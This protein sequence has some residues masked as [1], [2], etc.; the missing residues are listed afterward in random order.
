MSS[1]GQ[2]S[3]QPNRRLRYL[4]GAQLF[5]LAT[6]FMLGAWWVRLVLRQAGKIR[7]LE[8]GLGL[9]ATVTEDHWVRTQRMVMWES[10]TYFALI[11]GVTGILFWIFWRDVKRSRGLQSFFASV[12]HE[13]RTPL[14]S[15]RLQAESIAE[16]LSPGQENKALIERLLQDTV[17]LESQVER[18]LELARVEGGG[19]VFT[20]ALPVRS[21]IQRSMKS[22]SGSYAGQVQISLHPQTSEDLVIEADPTSLQVIIKNIVENS[23]RHSQKAQVRIQISA[24]ASA[25]GAEVV[26]SD[27]GQGFQGEAKKLGNLFQKGTHSQGAGVGLYLVGAL[28]KR[29]GGEAF[30]QSPGQ[31][32]GF[33]TLLRFKQASLASLEREEALHG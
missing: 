25:Q 2:I 15:I 11:L 17:R 14:T 32:Q 12:T 18:T 26:F 3:A 6:V 16:E 23:V 29:M 13:L 1:R 7:E 4:L 30:F 9:A 5:W 19:P 22:W 24:H 8:T 20:R 28:M 31:L 21:W 27:D 10:S 33:E